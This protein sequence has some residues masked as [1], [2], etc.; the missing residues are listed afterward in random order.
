M[1]ASF[2]WWRELRRLSDYAAPFARKED[3][4][5]KPAVQQFLRSRPIYQVKPGDGI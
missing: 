3:E 4:S 5:L 2:D 1:T